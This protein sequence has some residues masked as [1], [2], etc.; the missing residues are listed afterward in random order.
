[1]T[2]FHVTLCLTLRYKC[3][4]WGQQCSPVCHKLSGVSTRGMKRKMNWESLAFFLLTTFAHHFCITEWK[5]TNNVRVPASRP[6]GQSDVDLGTLFHYWPMKAG[7]VTSWGGVAK[8]E[9]KSECLYIDKQTHKQLWGRSYACV[10]LLSPECV[11]VCVL[12]LRC[13]S[14]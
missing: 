4:L 14:C 5:S 2:P 9:T 1:M 10:P 3:V 12:L 11:N 13:G 6:V 8:Q 7:S